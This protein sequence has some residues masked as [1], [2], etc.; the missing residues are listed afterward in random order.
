MTKYPNLIRYL[1]ILK[2]EQ[3]LGTRLFDMLE[4]PDGE[5]KMAAIRNDDAIF[6]FCDVIMS[7]DA[8]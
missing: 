4:I 3:T 6:A 5:F 1:A 2:A 7:R 8:V